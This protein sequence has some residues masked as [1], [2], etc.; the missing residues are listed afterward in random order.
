MKGSRDF[1]FDLQITL[2]LVVYGAVCQLCEAMAKAA[3]GPADTLR[4]A[5]SETVPTG[6]CLTVA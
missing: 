3:K 1:G 4:K 2:W 6:F 5:K